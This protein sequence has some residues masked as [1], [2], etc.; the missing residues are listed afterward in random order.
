MNI[1]FLGPPG[2]GKGTHAADFSVEL[3]IPHI[4][5]GDIFREAVKNQ[6]PIGKKA[7]E[8]MDRG[9]LVPDD[10][11]VEVVVDRLKKPDCKK[12]FILDGFPRN[13]AQAEKLSGS[14]HVN[15]A[16]AIYFATS[17]ETILMRLT[18]RRLCK[19]CGAGYHI[20]NIPPKKAGICDKCGGALYQRDDDKAETIE[21]RL[22]VYDHETKAL[23][24]YY[25][26]RKLLIQVTGD[27]EKS[28]GH[29]ELE[30]VFQRLRAKPAA[31]Q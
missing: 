19:K 30:A 9:E 3:G 4:S 5:T 11:V 31:K 7:K 15:L 26:S 29:A 28:L 24:D 6:T 1:I 20:K 17:K 27:F 12:G 25:R 22:E 23:L 13:I 16:A 21:H 14:L 18:G 8:F 10:I 2:A